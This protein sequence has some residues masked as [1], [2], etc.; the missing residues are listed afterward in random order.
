MLERE[1]L[2]KKINS[3][4]LNERLPAFK[5]NLDKNLELIKHFGGL[6]PVISRFAG[7]DI[8]IVGAGPSLDTA[9]P[10]LAK[11]QHRGEILIIAADM[12]LRPLAARGIMPAFVITCETTPVDYFADVD[13]RGI[14][15][16]AFSCASNSNIRRWRGPIRFYNW[17]ISGDDY[18]PLW[19]TA[20]LE[21]GSLATG[22]IVTTQAVSL[23]LGCGIRSILLCANDLGFTERFY[24]ANSIR[25]KFNLLTNSRFRT[26]DSAELGMA[27]RRRTCEIRRGNK[28]FFSDNQFL[29]AKLWLEELFKKTGGDIYDCGEPGCAGN[30]IKKIALK[31]YLS[32]YDRKKRGRKK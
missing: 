21:L 4:V 15:L 32:R 1:N 5:R 24:A 22:S 14:E 11:Y 12:A 7:R 13:T 26:P 19:E 2:Y 8:I 3:G 17:L 9:A 31:D 25:H 6:E 18:S 20:G 29:T 27:M 28:S 16:L 30:N 23:A 10:V